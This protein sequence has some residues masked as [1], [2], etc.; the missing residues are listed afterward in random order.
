M[1]HEI[2]INKTQNFLDK[3]E[4][5]TLKEKK[6]FHFRTVINFSYGIK[7]MKTKKADSLKMLLMNYYDELE[8]LDYSILN[9][10]ESWSLY[11]K[12]LHPIGKFLI[13]EKDFRSRASIYIYI[14]LG[15]LV[16][17]LSYYFFNYKFY[18]L[19]SLIMIF[20]GYYKL[21]IKKKEKKYFNPFW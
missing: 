19:A 14:H 17:F 13:D 1:N 6:L 11:K 5:K 12:Y 8:G 4:G 9:K 18:L 3:I 16:D 21:E 2:I 10:Q 15:I 7:Y 20:V